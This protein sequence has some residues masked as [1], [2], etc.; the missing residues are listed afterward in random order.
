MNRAGPELP[1]GLHTGRE[2]VQD[3]A[4]QRIGLGRE[5]VG[6]DE[7]AGLARTASFLFSNHLVSFTRDLHY[8]CQPTAP[9]LMRGCTQ[10]GWAGAH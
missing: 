8:D 3:L 4:V 9:V 7:V 5:A 6:V 1:R 2:A 10:P